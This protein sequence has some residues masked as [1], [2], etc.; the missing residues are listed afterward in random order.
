MVNKY[1]YDMPQ[2]NFSFQHSLGGQ[3]RIDVLVN[4]RREVSIFKLWVLD[5]NKQFTRRIKSTP[6]QRIENASEV[7]DDVLSESIKDILGWKLCELGGPSGIS[8]G[9]FAEAS[10]YYPK[11]K[12]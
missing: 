4:E 8:R 2:W 5:D 11:V 12:L 7:L 10:S 6:I 3:G 9:N 1:R